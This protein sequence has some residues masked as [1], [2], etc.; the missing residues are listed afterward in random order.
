MRKSKLYTVLSVMVIAMSTMMAIVAAPNVSAEAC[1]NSEGV[2]GFPAW[3]KGLE[4]DAMTGGGQTVNV[5][6][7]INKIWVIVMNIVQWLIVAGGYVA[8]FFIIFGG[9]KYIVAKGEPD[10]INNARTTIVNAIIGL[11]IV[12]ASVAIIRTIQ[13]SISGVIT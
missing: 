13:A 11:I 5:S 7:D 12:L 8:V 10:K 2:L 9:F 3:Y 4:C 6:G 1:K